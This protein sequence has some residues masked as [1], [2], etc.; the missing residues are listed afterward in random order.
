[1]AGG[2]AKIHKSI[3]KW[4]WY[5]DIPVRLTFIHLILT[6]NWEGKQWRGIN[7]NRGQVVTGTIETPK[8][9][10]VSTQQFR[11]AISKLKSTGEITT[12][13][14]N[15]N[16]IVTITNYGKYN[17][18]KDVPTT[19]STRKQ[20]AINNQTNNQS[21][22]KS[23]IKSTINNNP[24]SPINNENTK[25][26]ETTPTTNPTGKQNEINKQPNATSTTTKEDKKIR[27]KET[28]INNKANGLALEIPTIEEFLNHAME[29][30][31]DV[32]YDIDQKA[33]KAKYL[34]WRDN[35]WNIGGK[36]PREIKNWKS[37][38]TN[39][40]KYLK[41]ETENGTIKKKRTYEHSGT[42]ITY[43]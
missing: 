23:T 10:G 9:I 7:I 1:M 40:I 35:G 19:N 11:T 15:K 8:E 26:K 20:H 14:T 5:M 31:K 2:F 34:S 4:E 18:I 22:I 43:G 33:V 21:T 6:A 16:T 28:K 25:T 24:V 17:S 32:G 13:P 12:N 42:G 3:L 37:T 39:T 41:K 27:I 38:L 29:R 30:A 36:S